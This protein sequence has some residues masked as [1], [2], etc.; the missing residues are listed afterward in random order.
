M[1]CCHYIACAQT[2]SPQDNPVITINKVTVAPTSVPI[3]SQVTFTIAV[4]NE[5]ISAIANN[6][7]VRDTF[8]VGLTPIAD[9]VAVTGGGGTQPACSVQCMHCT[10]VRCT[11]CCYLAVRIKSHSHSPCAFSSSLCYCSTLLFAHFP[12]QPIT[13]H[14]STKVSQNLHLAT[15]CYSSF[16]HKHTHT[17]THSLHVP[18]G[19]RDGVQPGHRGRWC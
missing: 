13:K 12:A 2:T 14:S 16:L 19:A 15:D 9:S 3:G 4:L 8:P 10:A 17:H 1:C 6:V 7:I 11:V 18:Q 5:A